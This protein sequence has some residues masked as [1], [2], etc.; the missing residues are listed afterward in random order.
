M[1]NRVEIFTELIA[2]TEKLLTK[3]DI[4]NLGKGYSRLNDIV[5]CNLIRKIAV[6]EVLKKRTDICSIS[7]SIESARE[8][9]ICLNINKEKAPNRYCEYLLDSILVSET[10][11]KD[12]YKAALSELADIIARDLDSVEIKE[13]VDVNIVAMYPIYRNNTVN[14]RAM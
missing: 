3:G 10:D 4:I 8:F 11:D 6:L 7:I 1:I 14:V 5:R 13:I 2:D 9:H 12:N